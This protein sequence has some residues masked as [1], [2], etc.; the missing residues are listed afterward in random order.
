MNNDNSKV[1]EMVNKSDKAIV[2]EPRSIFDTAIVAFDETNQQV[3]YSY[4][5]MVASLAK[6]NQDSG[7]CEEGHDA[8]TMAVEWVDYNTLRAI[9]YMGEHHPIV[10]VWNDEENQLERWDE[11]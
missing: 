5:L 9:P 3:L 11:E 10:M 7:S 1:L 2:L 4:D 8:Y 6:D